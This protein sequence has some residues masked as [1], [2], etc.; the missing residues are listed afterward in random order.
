MVAQ[1]LNSIV[2][3]P[4]SVSYS[5][6]YTSDAVLSSLYHYV[7]RASMDLQF[8]FFGEALQ[9]EIVVLQVSYAS[10]GHV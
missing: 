10:D 7:M 3:V 1:K 9:V 8:D 5:S 2:F 6:W 4:S